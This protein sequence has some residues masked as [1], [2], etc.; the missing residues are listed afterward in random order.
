MIS[1]Q[2]KSRYDSHLLLHNAFAFQFGWSALHHAARNGNH[3]LCTLLIANGADPA[4]VN[5]VR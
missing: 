5:E 4:A 1:T 3:E 2:L